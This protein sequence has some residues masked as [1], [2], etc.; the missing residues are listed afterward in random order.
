MAS[1]IIPAH[2]R[3]KKAVQTKGPQRLPAGPVDFNVPTLPALPRG[4]KPARRGGSRLLPRAALGVFRGVRLRARAALGQAACGGR[5]KRPIA[6][7][8]TVIPVESTNEPECDGKAPCKALQPATSVVKSKTLSV[9]RIARVLQEQLHAYTRRSFLCDGAPGA[10][11]EA[12]RRPRSLPAAEARSPGISTA[13][14]LRP[15]SPRPEFQ[16]ARQLVVGQYLHV[17]RPYAPRKPASS[18]PQGRRAQTA[19]RLATGL[20]PHS[21]RRAPA[22]RRHARGRAATSLPGRSTRG[23]ARRS[24]SGSINMRLQFRDRAPAQRLRTIALRPASASSRGPRAA[25]HRAS[26]ER[27]HRVARPPPV[28]ASSSPKAACTLH[29]AASA[30]VPTP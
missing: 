9:R 28:R 11:P 16:L 2:W 20:A 1:L 21:A 7:C 14:P 17:Q 4:V 23:S 15:R 6:Y 24:V 29:R 25:A 30:S 12:G 3:P 10:K 27:A 8:S 18:R 5:A 22:A 13:V 19:A 26:P